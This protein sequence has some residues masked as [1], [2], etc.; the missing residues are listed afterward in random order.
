MLGY[1]TR[2]NCSAASVL[3][4]SNASSVEY[5]RR[6]AVSDSIPSSF[7][8]VSLVLE[9]SEVAFSANSRR[10]LH[11]LMYLSRTPCY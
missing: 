10:S 7:L 1:L 3:P 4:L 5:E 11:G 9:L 2:Q 8:K 6:L